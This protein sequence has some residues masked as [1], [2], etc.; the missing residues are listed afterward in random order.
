MLR[1]WKKVNLSLEGKKQ[2]KHGEAPTIAKNR[3][4]NPKKKKKH[5]HKKPTEPAHHKPP[6]RKK[7]AQNFKFRGSQGNTI[8][9]PS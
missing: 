3:T 7:K 9:P 6:E 4:P 8:I 5:P 1:E 2:E